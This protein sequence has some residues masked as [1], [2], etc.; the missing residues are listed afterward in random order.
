MERR[1]RAAALQPDSQAVTSG[2][3]LS[4]SRHWGEALR[5]ARRGRDRAWMTTS[6]CFFCT[7]MY[8]SKSGLRASMLAL[9]LSSEWPRSAMSRWIFH[10]NLTSSLMS[11]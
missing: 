7:S 3:E 11:R 5:L 6:A 2:R 8:A 10:A 9:M 4:H 1:G